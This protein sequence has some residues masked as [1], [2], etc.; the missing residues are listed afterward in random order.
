[1]GRYLAG[2]GHRSVAWLTHAPATEW[3]QQRLQGVREGLGSAGEVL[4]CEGSAAEPLSR[5]QTAAL[6]RATAMLDE[7]GKAFPIE[8]QRSQ[9]ALQTA[10]IAFSQAMV[11]EQVRDALAPQFAKARARRDVSAWVCASDAAAVEALA[12]MQREGVAVPAKVSVVG[13]DNSEEA[14]VR[15]LTSYDFNAAGLAQAQLGHLLRWPASAV[16][17]GGRQVTVVDGSV[18]ERASCALRR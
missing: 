3:S 8:R 14:F 2:L 5:Q 1:V 18:V 6:Q 17:A 4:V 12:F 9:Q 11:A 15:Q 10:A 13:F 7:A 16:R